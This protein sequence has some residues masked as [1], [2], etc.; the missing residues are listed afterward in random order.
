MKSKINTLADYRQAPFE[1]QI[2][3]HCPEEYVQ[4]QL[5]HLTRAYKKTEPV[6][7]V[8]N[9]DVVV[10]AVESALPKF[11]RPMVPV[12]VGGKLYDEE[13]EEQL[14]GHSVGETFQAQVQGEPVTVTIRQASRTVFPEPTDEMAAAYAAQHEGFAEIKT[15][16][17]YRRKVTDEYL[18]GQKKQVLFAAMNEIHAY[19]LSHSDWEFDEEELHQLIERG[20]EEFR[21]SLAEEG[22]SLDTLTTEELIVEFGVNSPA[23]LE[24]V[25]QESAEYQIAT[26]LWLEAINGCPGEETEDPWAFLEEYVRES[27]TIE[28]EH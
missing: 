19:V 10:L 22:K 2:T 17:E 3:L 13:L 28:E 14:P 20:Q 18:D 1:R 6:T 7:Q 15:V 4:T 11:N 24:G 27:L 26:D 21:E 9:G 23:E 5:R 8:E 25:F 12:T 16:A